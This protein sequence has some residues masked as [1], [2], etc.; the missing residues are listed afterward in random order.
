MIKKKFRA[1]YAL[2]ASITTASRFT[3]I[4]TITQNDDTPKRIL[5]NQLLE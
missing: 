5:D 4:F 3:V 2:D 1:L